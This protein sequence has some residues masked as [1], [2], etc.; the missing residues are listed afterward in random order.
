MNESLPSL[1]EAEARDEQAAIGAA[2]FILSLRAKGIR[3]TA[4]LRAMELVPREVFAP[5]R[6]TDLARTD[7]AL[8][9]PCGQTMTGPA[10][11][12]A[13]LLAL[14]VQPGQRILEIGTGSGYVTALLARLGAEV[15]SVE[16]FNT[17]AESAAQHL[18]IVDAGRVRLEVGDGLATRV[19]DRF[20][21]I[22]L[23]GARPEIP[24]AVI[25]LLPPGGR[26]V[27]AL[28]LEGMPRLVTIER[29]G[30]GDLGQS[31]GGSLRISP[32]VTGVAATL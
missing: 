12:A 14:G 18:K 8:P 26:L 32:L 20:D 23:N 25:S 6:F 24:E 13:M 17:L 2:S 3:D 11:V 10:T 1:P 28:T 27:G 21:R 9:L 15:T 29:D 22:L 19:R 16:R 4:L 7:V 30:K 5:R 31:L